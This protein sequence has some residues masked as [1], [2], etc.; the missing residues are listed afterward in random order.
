MDPRAPRRLRIAYIVGRFPDPTQTFVVNQ[1][2][3]MAER[4]HSIEVFTTAKRASTASVSPTMERLERLGLLERTHAIWAAGNG[5]LALCKATVLLLLVGWRAPGI[6]GRVAR[7]APTEGVRAALHLLYAALTLVQ[8]GRPSYDVIHAQFG[9]YGRLAARLMEL[10]VL[11]GP[12]IT[13]FRGYD[14]GQYLSAHA[15]DYRSLFARGDLFLPVCRHLAERLLAAG[16]DA[17]KIHVHHSG[18][19]CGSM[20]YRDRPVPKAAPLR[21]ISIGRLVEKK[22]FSYAIQAVAHLLA[23]SRPVSYVIVGDGPSRNELEAQIHELDLSA[24]VTLVGWKRHDE[25]LQLLELSHLLLVPS[26]TA[27]DGDEEGIPNVAKE[28]MAL[29]LPVVAT[30]HGGIPELVRDGVSGYLVPERDVESLVSCLTHLMDH[31]ERWTMMGRAGRRV[32]EDHFD[33]SKLST[34]LETLYRDVGNATE[35]AGFTMTADQRAASPAVNCSASAL[36]PISS[37]QQ[38][39]Q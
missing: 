13:S 3:A 12:L 7:T 26:V 2:V 31:R 36:G 34:E 25:A 19:D 10:G 4:G 24:H 15:E 32:V 21:L 22:G 6:L 8:R 14:A 18:V 27:R 1:I 17:K 38:G 35:A 29:G 30:K 5:L 9:P 33:V 11:A 23:A 20:P 39:R 16:C 28:A 37:I